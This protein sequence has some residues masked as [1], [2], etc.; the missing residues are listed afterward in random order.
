M[1]FIL[2][3]RRALSFASASLVLLL[4]GTSHAQD[5]LVLRVADSFPA[6]GHYF[7]RRRRSTSWRPSSARPMA[8]SNSSTTR[9][10]RW[11][12]PRTCSR[13]PSAGAVD[14]GSVMPSYVSEKMPLS[15]VAELPGGF[16][17][18]C[19]GTLAYWKL[20][21][22]GVLAANEYAPNGIRVLFVL[23]SVPYQV[24]MKQKADSVE[25]ARRP[26]VAIHRRLD[27][28]RHPQ[29]QRGADPHGRTRDLRVAVARHARWRRRVV[30]GG[31]FVQPAHPRQVG[32]RRREFRQRGADLL[33]QR[34]ALEVAAGQRAEGH[35]RR[36]RRRHPPCLRADGRE[37]R[38]RSREDPPGRCHRACAFPRQNERSPGAIRRRGSRMG[39]RTRS[40]RQAGHRDAEGVLRSTRGSRPP[41]RP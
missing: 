28:H 23:V 11:A 12:R 4:S 38:R 31:A 3:G 14:I 2:P 9:P 10:S 30:R 40:A 5:K 32:H 39:E 25:G 24:L 21:R 1:R 13:S 7:S 15:A 37:H 18:S 29:A 41:R 6:S 19:E 26:Q 36:R 8:R 34:D 33:D 27:R 35:A 22:D 17:S 20:A 16:A